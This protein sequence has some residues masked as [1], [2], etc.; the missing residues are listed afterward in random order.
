MS[1]SCTFRAIRRVSVLLVLL[2]VALVPVAPAA[3]GTPDRTEATA[4]AR[5]AYDYG[6]PLLEFLRVRKE[7]TSVKA[8]DDETNAPVNQFGHAGGF[9]GPENRTVVAPN[10]DTL[11]SISHL[12]LDREPI[13]L[14]HP[15]MGKRFFGFEFLDPYTNVVGYVGSRTTGSKARRT[16]IVWTGAPKAKIPRGVKVLR[17]PYRR[18]WVIGRTLVSGERDLAAAKK[19]MRQYSLVPLSKLDD[20]PRRSTRRPGKPRKPTLPAGVAYFDA[21]AT[22][23]KQNPPPKRDKAILAKL[24]RIG[25]EPGRGPTEAGVSDDIRAALLDG[26]TAAKADVETRSRTRALQGALAQ[27]GWYTPDPDIGD[28]GTDY[29]FRAEIAF[30]G[31]G[32]NTP[33]EAT[34]PI[35]LAD[36][37]G[38]LLDS[39]QRY[40]V[41]FPANDQPPARAFWSLTMYDI[42]GYLVPNEPEIYAIG[43]T[44]PPL[45]TRPDG[46]VVVAV[47]RD[48]PSDPTVNWLPTPATGLFRLNLRLYWPRP[49]ALNGTWRPPPVIR[50]P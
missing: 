8:P 48:R 14:A 42:T 24:A 49:A 16:A 37:E 46:S 19:L 34:Y 31:L 5:E 29:A 25:I 44:H 6:L 35:A 9:P 43:D 1:H 11:Y 33:D 3:A 4:I 47:Q 50:A 10:V 20:P 12:D 40:T 17:V 18:I 30:A 45:V 27:G 21:L 23:M 38:R 32:A 39:G 26:Y 28:Y 36:S 2:V 41:K 15:S 13:V 22:A 7:N